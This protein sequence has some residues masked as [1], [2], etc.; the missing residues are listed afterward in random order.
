MSQIE[1]INPAASEQTQDV[2]KSM[3][4]LSAAHLIAEFAKS[5]VQVGV[6]SPLWNGAAEAISFGHL[7]QV[8]IVDSESARNH[9]AEATAQTL[10][11]AAGLAADGVILSKMHA[12]F[13]RGVAVETAGFRL[14]GQKSFAHSLLSESLSSKHSL[15]FLAKDSAA[16][17][18]EAHV[19]EVTEPFTAQG[20]SLAQIKRHIADEANP[21]AKYIARV[22]KEN[23]VTIIGEFHNKRGPSPHR[24]LGIEALSELPPGSTLAVEFP[25][26]FRPIFDEFNAGKPGTDFNLSSPLA[27]SLSQQ[28][29]LKFLQVLPHDNPEI[30]DL[31][32]S[33]RDRG[34]RIIPIDADFDT[35]GGQYTSR[36][37]ERT[38]SD[39]LVALHRED[40]SKPVVAWSGNLHGARA[41]LRDFES[42]A[43]Q[44]AQTPEFASGRSK[45]ST[46]YSQIAETETKSQPLYAV[47]G[48]LKEPLA[49]P[50]FRF[51]P[52][53]ERPFANVGVLP[54]SEVGATGMNVKLGDYDHAVMYP[55]ATAEQTRAFFRKQFDN[56]DLVEDRFGRHWK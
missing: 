19:E 10:G 7:P 47:A 1:K 32:K 50:T 39:Q 15:S 33:V 14:G 25:A 48:D 38:L 13:F 2:D 31:W 29:A 24:M 11:A 51:K 5:A 41:N 44:L 42:F 40:V 55:P 20:T 27:K 22:I 52:E 23:D 35:Y 37:R 16:V 36:T 6:I 46:I 34:S 45:L 8:S 53:A 43:K 28:R 3:Q 18:S 21:A 30:L 49:F 4:R 26:S 12:L 9:P 54:A 56:S 17:A